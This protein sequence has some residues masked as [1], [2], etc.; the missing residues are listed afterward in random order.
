MYST[1]PLQIKIINKKICLMLFYPQK[2]IK[3]FNS[4]VNLEE[5]IHKNTSFFFQ[6]VTVWGCDQIDSKIAS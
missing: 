6:F 3:N 4:E 1:P 5:T 2:I